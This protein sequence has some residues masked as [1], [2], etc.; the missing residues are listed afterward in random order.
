MNNKENIIIQHMDKIY[1]T[2]DNNL[3]SIITAETG[4]GKSVHII[5]ELSK[6]YNKI[7]VSVP[8]KISA[9]SLA[10]YVGK[11]YSEKEVGYAAD[12]YINYNKKTNIIYA[13]SGHIRKK[14]IKEV[15]YLLSKKKDKFEG[16]GDILVVDESHTGSIDNTLIIS[17]WIAAY[18]NNIKVPKL[19]LLSA[20]PTDIKI[21]PE[22]KV[23]KIPSKR[24]YN[25]DIIYRH[26]L[27]PTDINSIVVNIIEEINRKSKNKEDGI[28]VF[29]AGSKD[30][31]D[32]IDLLNESKIRN[33]IEAYS[34]YSSMPKEE[35]QYIHNKPNNIKRK[36]I[37]ATNIAESSITIEGLSY[38]IDTMYSK[39]LAPTLSEATK[40]QKVLIS[41]DSAKQR[42][43]RVGRTKPGICYRLISEAN[44]EKLPNHKQEEINIVPLHNIIMELLESKIDPNY[45]IDIEKSSIIRSIDVLSALKLI[46]NKK[47]KI[48]DIMSNNIDNLEFSK[49][50]LNSSEISDSSDSSD[51]S[52]ISDSE[53][54]LDINYADLYCVTD[55][56][57]CAPNLVLSVRNHAFLWNWIYEG[58]N[59]YEGIVI[60]CIIDN[61]SYGYFKS[62]RNIKNTPFKNLNEYYDEYFEHWYGDNGLITYLNMWNSFIKWLK[63]KNLLGKFV[64]NHHYVKY[65]QWIAENKINYKEFNELVKNIFKIYNTFI[66]KSY[67]FP[68]NNYDL[69]IDIFDSYQAFNFAKPI[70]QK[71]YYNS[72]MTYL[73]SKR[74]IKFTDPLGI[75]YFINNKTIISTIE[76][77]SYFNNDLIFLNN[78]IVALVKHEIS[79]NNTLGIIDLGFIFD[80]KSN[81]NLKGIDTFKL[82]NVDH[83]LTFCDLLEHRSNTHNSD[84]L[85]SPSNSNTWQSRSN[86]NTWQ[87]R[88]NLNSPSNSNT[89][90]P[91]SNLNSPS[92]S[93][94]WKSRSNLNSPSNSNTW[95]SRSNLNSP[96]NS[97]TWQSRSNLNSPSNANTWQSRSNINSPSNANTWKSRYNRSNRSNLNVDDINT[98]DNKYKKYSNKQWRKK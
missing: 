27:D 13:T 8:T 37:V 54:N 65:N 86:S 78:K 5:G 76:K 73:D 14:I 83:N 21:I 57:R 28:L 85:N 23:Y 80:D 36:I 64:K 74:N 4:S 3:V 89:W 48:N 47:Y 84:I 19:V 40:L 15:G 6:K 39:E 17:M 97:N 53:D 44:Y 94:T 81:F 41:K 43:G 88:S 33:E 79:G 11:I 95:Q 75:I 49:I 70:L 61:Y 90:Q 58:K 56:G 66:T 45:I 12:S 34:A 10:D 55:S 1:E 7:F 50:N 91:R 77:N 38:V 63:Q 51:I 98:E 52:D 26:V 67:L 9:T 87:P 2:I 59:P 29:V 30:T 20:T 24:K 92:N 68:S 42:A 31:H 60:A 96:S 32:I 72:I 46:I 71:I 35:L 69:N 62:P 25:V 22:P 93:N 18:K 82:S 16:M